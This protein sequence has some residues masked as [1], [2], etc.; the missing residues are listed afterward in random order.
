MLNPSTLRVVHEPHQIFHPCILGLEPAL[1]P[2]FP[3]KLQDPWQIPSLPI[4]SNP[5][6]TYNSPPSP[7][8]ETP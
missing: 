5:L 3:C 1:D 8:M 7:P 2:D 6:N 4:R